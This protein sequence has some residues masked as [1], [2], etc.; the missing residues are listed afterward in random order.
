MFTVDAQRRPGVEPR[1]HTFGSGAPRTFSMTAQRRPGVE[2]R[3]HLSLD[4]DRRAMTSHR[5]T[6]AGGRTPA[7]L[8][9][10]EQ[11]AAKVSAAQRRPGVEPRRHACSLMADPL[12]S[13]AQRR[14][15]VE[16]R[17]HGYASQRMRRGCGPLNEGRGSNPGDTLDVPVLWPAAGGAQRRP[18]VEPRRH[19]LH[20]RTEAIRR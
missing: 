13:I 20:P 1:R 10:N 2:P 19:P 11:T 12:S 15:G 16:P 7:T 8:T 4:G 18:G 5:S 14:P 6:K 3:R 17:R 9:V